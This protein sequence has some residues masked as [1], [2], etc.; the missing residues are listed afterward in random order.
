MAR[1]PFFFPKTE[2]RIEIFHLWPSNMFKRQ[3]QSIT[4]QGRL[5]GGARD[6]GRRL[7]IAF[8]WLSATK[9]SFIL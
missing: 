1:L 3:I 6:T 8:E 2:C 5:K 9:G 4:Q 7:V